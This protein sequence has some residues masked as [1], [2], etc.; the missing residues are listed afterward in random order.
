MKLQE[1]ISELQKEST[2]IQ[3]AMGEVSIKFTISAPFVEINELCRQTGKE[4]LFLNADNGYYFTWVDTTA[5]NINILSIERFKTQIV[6][7]N[8]MQPTT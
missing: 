6:E 1:R 4:P 8:E 2:L 3:Q 7:I 5:C